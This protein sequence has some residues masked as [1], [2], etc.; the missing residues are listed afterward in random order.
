MTG[1]R[2]R[3]HLLATEPGIYDGLNTQYNGD[4]FSDMHF[5]VHVVP[6]KDLEQWFVKVKKSS[7]SLTNVSYNQLLQPSMGDK[8]KKFSSVENDLFNKVI[9]TYMSSVGALHPRQTTIKFHKE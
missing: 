1:M 2:T 9:M 8:P 6:P 7:N 5:E 4:G 3:L